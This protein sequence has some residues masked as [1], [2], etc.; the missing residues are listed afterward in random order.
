MLKARKCVS[1]MR[2]YHSPVSSPL[3]ELRLDMN[4]STTGC[5]PRVLAK[6]NSMDAKTLAY[7]PPREPAEKAM[8]KFLGRKPSEIL[9][10]NG[11]DEG[12]DLVCRAFLDPG[13]EIV[14]M[15]PAFDMYAVFAQV[16]GAKVVHVPVGPEFSFPLQRMID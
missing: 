1:E 14:I 12:I 6:L 13:D 2:E 16:P 11:A 10:T 7:Y 3:A 5:S 8:A 4:E 15:V 9:L